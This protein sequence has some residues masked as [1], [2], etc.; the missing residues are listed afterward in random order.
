MRIVEFRAENVK[1]LKV[2]VIHP[3]GPLVQLTGSNGSGKTSV[4]DSILY[5]LA[6]T[7]DLPSQP[8]RK[9]ADKGGV[10]IDLG[11]LRVMRKF[12]PTGNVLIVE[13]KKG[14]RYQ[15]PQQMLDKLFGN[16][17]FDPLA[18]TRMKTK[19]QADALR[20]LVRMDV[21][22]DE[23]D[24]QIKAEY[25][26]RT[27]ANR[28]IKGL[29][30]QVDA[31]SVVAELPEKPID[32]TKLITDLEQAGTKNADIVLRKQEL[33]QSLNDNARRIKEAEAQ[34]AEAADLERRAAEVRKNAQETLTL[35]GKLAKTLEAEEF[36][37]AIDTVAL[38]ESIENARATNSQIARRTEKEKLQ[39]EL[40][41]KNEYVTQLETS[42]EERKAKKAT[43]IA[44]ANMPVEGLGFENGEVMYMGLPLNQASGAEQL[45]VSCAIAMASN[46]EVRIIRITDGSL[47]DDTSLELIK[48]MAI[49]KDYQIW[50]ERV[51]TSGK[52]GIVME[53]GEVK[54]VNEE[55]EP[56]A[57]EEAKEPVSKAKKAAKK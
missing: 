32:I 27:I 17:T 4:L 18:F 14:E 5:A 54:T 24:N 11:D 49:A 52:I 6:G 13:G 57:A 39:A 28:A 7:E 33:N 41:E 19:D 26:E 37:E 38:R 46:P 35:A 16:L 22:I 8:I 20:S 9:G 34:I 21:D 40:D 53:D 15:K 36:P 56:V 55:P 51:D 30:A 43:A 42:M 29:Q 47:L 45:R 23:I 25:D 44:E 3:K 1:K 10:L 50:I 12:T 2:V 48:Q 31:I